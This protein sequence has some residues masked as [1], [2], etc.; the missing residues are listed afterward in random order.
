MKK[1]AEEK[2]RGVVERMLS[3]YAMQAGKSTVEIPAKYSNDLSNAYYVWNQ[4]LE[5]EE[6][7]KL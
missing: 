4:Y 3:H 5:M 2:L 7:G 1:E 6:A